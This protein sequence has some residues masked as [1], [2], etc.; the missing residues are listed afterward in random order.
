MKIDG[1]VIMSQP[2]KSGTQPV[3]HSFLLFGFVDQFPLFTA[4]L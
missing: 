1:A 4:A 2:S 3:F